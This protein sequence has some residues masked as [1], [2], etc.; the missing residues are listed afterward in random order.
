MT[1]KP[2]KK[3]NDLDM[4][5]LDDKGNPVG[6]FDPAGMGSVHNVGRIEVLGMEGRPGGLDEIVFTCV[7]IMHYRT[8]SRSAIS[9]P[10]VAF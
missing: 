7:A 5:L 1:W 2:Q 6:R 8:V 3:K 9:V 10:V 4:A